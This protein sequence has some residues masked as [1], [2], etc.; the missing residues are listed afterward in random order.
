LLYNPITCS[1]C[2]E[3]QVGAKLR[4]QVS[5]GNRTKVYG[6]GGQAQDYG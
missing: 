5:S 2:P 4:D 3:V 6:R 1:V